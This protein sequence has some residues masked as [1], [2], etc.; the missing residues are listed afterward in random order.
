MRGNLLVIHHRRSLSDDVVNFIR[1]HLN[2]TADD[3]L[4]YFYLLI[5]LHK[6]PISGRPVCLDCSSLPHALGQWVDKSLQPIV[7]DQALYFKNSAELKSEMEQ[8]D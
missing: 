7:Q 2:N 6:T 8:L 5:K 1:K 3:P 4:G